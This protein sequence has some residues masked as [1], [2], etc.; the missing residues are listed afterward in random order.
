MHPRSAWKGYSP[1]FR[2]NEPLGIEI[3]GSENR[4][5]GGTKIALILFVEYHTA[6]R[7]SASYLMDREPDLEGRGSSKS[8]TAS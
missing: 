1:E 8:S 6:F 5:I 3:N 7:Q 4:Q 2:R